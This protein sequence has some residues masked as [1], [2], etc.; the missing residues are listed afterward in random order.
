MI[1][2]D[3]ETASHCD[4]G[5]AGVYRYAED[6]TTRILCIAWTE[7]DGYGNVW[8][9]RPLRGFPRSAIPDLPDRDRIFIQSFPP[10][11]LLEPF[12]NPAMPLVAHNASFERI[13]L[14]SHACPGLPATPRERWYCTMAQ[15]QTCN[16]PAD[17]KTLSKIVQNRKLDARNIMLKL[18]RPNKEGRLWE[19]EDMP[20][21]F[22]FLYKYCIQDVYA[23]RSVYNR[24]PRISA[25]ERK[26]Y[27]LS[28][29]INDRGIQ[30]DTASV[31][32]A[33][34]VWQA[35]QAKLEGEITEITGGIQ[36]GQ[37]GKL[38]DWVRAQGYEI[39]N[40]Q[41]P[42]VAEALKDLKGKP[43]LK[44]VRRVLQC[45]VQHQSK[46]PM[47]YV[48]MQ[49]AVCADG[50]LRGMFRYHAAG[51]GRWSSTIVQLQNIYR[52]DLK[53]LDVETAIRCYPHGLERL[54]WA[55]PD[56]PAVKVLASTVRGMLVASPGNRILASDFSQI[57]ARVLPWLAGQTGKLDALRNGIK[58]YEAVASKMFGVPVE[59][60]TSEQR[61]LGKI[62]ELACGYQGSDK[63]LLRTAAVYGLEMTVKKAIA[64]VTQWRLSNVEIVRFWQAIEQACRQAIMHP[65]TVYPIGEKLAAKVIGEFLCIRLPSGRLLRYFR[66]FLDDGRICFEGIDTYTRRFQVTST[67]GG[68]LAE[69]VTQAAARDVLVEAMLRLEQ[70]GHRIIGTVHDEVLMEGQESDVDKVLEL[71]R[72]NPAWA[73]DLPLDATGFADGRF[74]KD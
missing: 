42:V 66:P 27:L 4:L 50:R 19:P 58:L 64:L 40:L 68:K 32:A 22:A 71:M 2:I 59:Q 65:G 69:N 33:Q 5:K 25:R 34:A 7:G 14:N 15:A 62:G 3:I 38:A 45:R 18:A 8:V 54:E 41:A 60:V 72:V 56:L 24:F 73:A 17:L 67:Y 9:P 43:Q 26:V 53:P 51:T 46:A 52:G 6:P 23:E 44:H 47:K 36:P 70:A 39:D 20:E 1:H 61:L 11:E 48:A 35:C 21:D 10:E 74:R 57:E 29:A 31:D 12:K 63:A 30:V 28:E 37:T 49:R 13:L 55:F 16:L